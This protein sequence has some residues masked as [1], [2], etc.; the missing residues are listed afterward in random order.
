MSRYS[1]NQQSSQLENWLDP[2]TPS[3]PASCYIPRRHRRFYRGQLCQLDTY[4]DCMFELMMINSG[5]G[6]SGSVSGGGH[7][8]GNSSSG[9][10]SAPDIYRPPHN[11]IKQF[12]SRIPELSYPEDSTFHSCPC[13]MRNNSSSGDYEN[14]QDHDQDQGNSS[15]HS[16]DS[17]SGSGRHRHS[18]WPQYHKS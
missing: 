14:Y 9:S 12:N 18:E 1:I 6:S 16:S 2:H 10:S 5:T 4:D 17:D 3:C 7:P 13:H 8:S 11:A 15:G